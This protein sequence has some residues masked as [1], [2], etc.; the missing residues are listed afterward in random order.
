MNSKFEEI[1]SSQRQHNEI[2]KFDEERYQIYYKSVLSTFKTLGAKIYKD[3]NE[4]CCLLGS[5]IQEGITGFGKS[6][7]LAMVDFKNSL[8]SA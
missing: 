1:E 8:E 2:L 4:W 7:F 5:N 3:G 6:P